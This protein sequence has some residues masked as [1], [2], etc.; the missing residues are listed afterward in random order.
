MLLGASKARPFSL[1]SAKPSLMPVETLQFGTIRRVI[2]FGGAPLLVAAVRTLRGFGIEV[3][4]FTS[5]RHA[6]EV[7]F[8]DGTTLAQALEKLQQPFVVSD[9]INTEGSLP[10]LISEDTLGI[11]LGEAW[12]FD[13]ALIESFGSR[14]FDFMGIP[15]PRYRGGA[16]YT[17]MIMRGER[18]MGCNLQVINEDMVQGEHDSGAIVASK[19][20]ELAP[21]VRTPEDYF[22]GAVEHEC[23][24]IEQFL[25][26]VKAGR[27][28]ELRPIDESKSMFLPRLHTR[29]NGWIDW[30]WSGADIDSFVRAFDV[31]YPGASTTIEDHVVQ[32]RGSRM[33]DDE[34]PFHPFQSGLITRI[35]S[36]GAVVIATTSGHLRI[37]EVIFDE[38]SAKVVLLPGMRFFTSKTAL[39]AS[40]AFKPVYTASAATISNDEIKAEERFSA[41]GVTLRLLQLEDCN[42][43]YLGWLLDPEVNRYLETRWSMQ[44]L[45]SIRE[46]VGTMLGAPDSHL[47]AIIESATGSHIGNLKIGP[48]NKRHSHADVSYFIGEK[49]LWGRGYATSAIQA[50]LSIAFDRLKIHR[51]QAGLYSGNAASSRALEKAGF[52]YEGAFR[53]QLSGPEGWEDHL[54]YGILNE[55]TPSP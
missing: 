35:E 28:F 9:D 20:Y 46:F 49:S 53:S 5:E 16:H 23:A 31:P 4:V 51:L 25:C 11:G 26:D 24:F 40:M 3:H 45:D 13:K 17:W 41:G 15:H 2:L 18:R 36:D 22:A 42:E 48:V 43:T 27:T 8:A 33:L 10:P 1:S 6:T 29:R 30:A 38:K 34:A 52:V 39:E 12:S 7:L 54:F 37:S 32:L 21:T 47:F 14:L 44:T 50:A 55:N 19:T